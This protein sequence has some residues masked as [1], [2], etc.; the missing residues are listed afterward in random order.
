MRERNKTKQIGG[1][2]NDM[3]KGNARKQNGIA[4]END[5]EGGEP[6]RE[7]ERERESERLIA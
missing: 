6:E 1:R 5:K 2:E 7:R 3:K 4:R